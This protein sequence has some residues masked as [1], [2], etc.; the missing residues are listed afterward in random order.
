MVIDD[1]VLSGILNKH[2]LSLEYEVQQA[3][4]H[5]IITEA[6]A[7]IT[8]AQKNGLRELLNKARA[9]M[10]VGK[11]NEQG[12]FVSC[13]FSFLSVPEGMEEY[14][15]MLKKNS[16]TMASKILQD[17]ISEIIHF[18]DVQEE[19]RSYVKQWAIDQINFA[20]GGISL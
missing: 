16:S 8:T 14:A 19:I 6:S 15:E 7:S 12:T 18:D 20:V 17:R 3:L 2:I 1:F 5:E 4:E 13:L 10:K 9:T 11:D